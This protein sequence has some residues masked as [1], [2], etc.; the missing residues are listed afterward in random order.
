MGE[1]FVL[2]YQELPRLREPEKFPG[3]LRRLTTTACGRYLRSRKAACQEIST[4]VDVP[5]DLPG[6]DAVIFPELFSNFSELFC[7]IQDT[8]CPKSKPLSAQVL[9]SPFYHHSVL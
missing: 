7:R 3:W 5:A 2:A 8:I 6:Q 1:A 4:A 9:Y